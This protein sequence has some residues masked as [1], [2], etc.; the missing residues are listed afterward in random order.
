V[1]AGLAAGHSTPQYSIH[2]GKLAKLLEA[3]VL[4]ELGAPK[5]KLGHK[6]VGRRETADGVECTFETKDGSKVTVL[7]DALIGCDGVRSGADS[8]SNAFKNMTVKIVAIFCILCQNR[9]SRQA[10]DT[11]QKR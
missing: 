7:A 11:H 6:F 9:L 8:E 2:R 4:R 5:L 3:A 10:R 1:F